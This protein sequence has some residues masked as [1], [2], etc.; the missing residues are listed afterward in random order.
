MRRSAAFVLCTAVGI[1]AASAAVDSSYV[2]H[3]GDQISVAVFGDAALSQNVTVL[4]DGDIQYP[5]VR[6]IHVAGLTPAAAASAIRTKMRQYIKQPMVTVNVVQEGLLN[7]VVLGAVKTPGK[8]QVRSDAHVMDAIAVA[9]GLVTPNGDLPVARISGRDGAF[10]SVSLQS[11][12]VNN[13]ASQN[14]PLTNDGTVYV[15]GPNT[16]RVDVL[17][18][19]DR[20][21]VID[22]NDGDRL[23]VALARAGLS[24]SRADLNHIA[25][26]RLDKS[27]KTQHTEFNMFLALEGGD[28]RY[29]PILHKDDSIFVPQARQKTNIGSGGILTRLLG[30]GLG[31]PL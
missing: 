29:D 22:V 25:I 18:A 11:L 6:R 8:Y 21:G 23:G 2:I 24:Q 26:T 31:L 17:G 4:S 19:V 7:I 10:Q 27:G 12:L 9:G 3:P 5:L 13:D 16:F 15:V 1:S 14:L 20:P 30:L 28:L